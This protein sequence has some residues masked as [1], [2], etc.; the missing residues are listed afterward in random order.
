MIIPKK[1]RALVLQGGGAVG[2]YEAGVIK[3]L[4]EK[5]TRE[6]KE[7]GEEDRL[8]FDIVGGTSIGAMNGAVLV[9]QFLQS[10]SWEDAIEKL[11]QFWN[12]KDKGLGSTL[13]AKELLSDMTRWQYDEQWY[14]KSA[15]GTAS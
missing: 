6:D 14:R 5:L 9:S 3:T 4:S 12:D 13:D 7:N 8:L 1:Q 15:T 2:A 10:R 11:Q